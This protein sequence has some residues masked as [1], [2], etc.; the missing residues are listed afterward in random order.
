[1]LDFSA[2][3]ENAVRNFFGSPPRAP[4]FALVLSGGGARAAYQAGV[5]NYVAD[6]FPDA[7]FPIVNGVSA[8]AINAAHLANFDGSFSAAA[9]D[10]TR[11]WEAIR[12]DDVYTPASSFQFI[13][14]F[15]RHV[16]GGKAASEGDEE[17][18]GLVDTA[19]LKKFL[20]RQL[21]TEDGRLHGVARNI[22]RGRLR[23]LAIATTRYE[24]GQTVTWVHGPDIKGWEQPNRVGI[25][26]SL[27]VD[28]ILASASLPILFPAVQI[29]DAWYGD[30]G[31]RLSAPISPVIDMGADRIFVISTRYDRS[32]YEADEPTVS[33]YPPP[34]TIIGVLMNA[35]FLDVLDRDA[36]ILERF[37]E[38]VAQIPGRQRGGLREI[39]MLLIRPSRDLS[40]MA[41]HYEA[42]PEGALWL[43]T[44][45]LGTGESSSPDWL[46][47][48]LF[49]QP[50]IHDLLEVGYGDARARHD[51][52]AEFIEMEERRGISL[53]RVPLTRRT[54]DGISRATSAV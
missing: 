53:P 16:L 50:Y 21:G 28:H 30:G 14:G 40:K 49:E 46:S 24:T 41:S 31:I 19:P 25:N 13:H 15:M 38:L 10:L 51:D 29:G 18:R 26:T 8:G 37:N 43:L 27:K 20:M 4:R 7:N 34:A 12:E 32:R 36:R 17:R 1:M 45:G 54:G 3:L 23:A 6:A 33:G 11:I 42:R 52:I 48:L 39:K 9:H 2:R 5:M 22:I 35:I 47:M 44:R